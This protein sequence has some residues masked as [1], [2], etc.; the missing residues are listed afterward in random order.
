MLCCGLKNPFS[1]Y[2]LAEKVYI[3]GAIAFWS[4]FRFS[5]PSSDF[6]VGNYQSFKKTG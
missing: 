1:I 4:V 6:D 5:R 2:A 3:D